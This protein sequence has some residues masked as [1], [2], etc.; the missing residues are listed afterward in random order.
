MTDCGDALVREKWEVATPYDEFVQGVE[1]YES[2]WHGLYERAQLPDWAVE[3]ATG[4]CQEAHFLVIAADWCWDTAV[5]LPI[6]ARLCDE[7]GCFDIR[8]IDRNEHSDLMDC[9]IQENKELIPVVIGM[10][11]EFKEVGH[12]GPQPSEIR[13]WARV[14]KSRMDKSEFYKQM[15]M[16]HVRDKGESIL[17]EV[18]GLFD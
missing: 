17:R 8:L 13:P 12:W 1:E 7:T 15:R 14:S 18:L 4:R 11:G 3:Q 10:D 6:L 16:W 2:L 9:Y 5:S